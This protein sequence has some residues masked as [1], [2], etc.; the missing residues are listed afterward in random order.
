MKGWLGSL[1]TPLRGAL[2]ALAGVLLAWLFLKDT[3]GVLIGVAAAVGISLVGI[4]VEWV[5]V[6]LLPKQPRVALTLLE[7]WILTP[8]VAA[9]VAAAVV[10]IVTVKAT[11]PDGTST[12][13]KELI[14]ALATGLTSFVTASFVDWASDSDDSSLA[15]RIKGHFQK[16]FEGRWE[17]SD[18]GSLLV[19]SDPFADPTPETQGGVGTI[20]GWGYAARRQRSRGLLQELA[21]TQ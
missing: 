8:A 6:K 10:T 12:E 4:L 16:V 20:S 21:N 5:G 17:N 2:V 3:N 15:D 19:H 11:L 7:W 9:A 18:R 1:T 13:T 14:A